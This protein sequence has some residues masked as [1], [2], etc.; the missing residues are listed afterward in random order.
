MGVTQV[1]FSLTQFCIENVTRDT[2]YPLAISNLGTEKVA[3]KSFPSL[4]T[5]LIGYQY[6]SRS[7]KQ[8]RRA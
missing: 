5:P 8:M 4:K 3:F 2:S 6:Q 1:I 7:G